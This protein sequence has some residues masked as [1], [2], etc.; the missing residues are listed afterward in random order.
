MSKSSSEGS[1]P[2]VGIISGALIL[3]NALALYEVLTPSEGLEPI[4]ILQGKMGAWKTALDTAFEEALKKN[5]DSVF[6]YAR[7][8]LASLPSAPYVEAALK[9]LYHSVQPVASK[10]TLLRND[11][12]GRVYHSALGKSIAKAYATFYTRI[13]TGELL[14]WFAIDDYR[15]RVSDF[16]C[17]SGTLLVASY[18]KKL[19]LAF[20]QGFTGSISDLHQEF[21]QDEV[22]GFDA[23]PFAS[24]L[25]L[26][27]LALQQPAVTFR[28]GR[29]YYVPCG[30][31]RMGSLDLLGS[32]T[33]A[34]QQRLDGLTAHGPVEQAMAGKSAPISLD[35]PRASFDLVIMNP[36]FTRNDRASKVLNRELLR[37]TLKAM[38]EGLSVAG[39]SAPFV[40]LAHISLKPGGRLAF[41]LPAAVLFADSWQPVRRLLLS[42]YHVE[43]IVMTWIPGASSFSE[44][45]DFREVLL[46]ARKEELKKEGDGSEEDEPDSRTL[47]AHLDRQFGVLEA[48]EIAQGL[49]D[50]G[51]AAPT[52]DLVKGNPGNITAS[53][54]PFGGVLACSD[55]L[56]RRSVDNW[57]RLVCIRD[58]VLLRL[59]LN[60]AGFLPLPK[61]P[62]GIQLTS[63]VSPISTFADVNLFMKNV[64]TAGYR[65]YE[66]RPDPGAIPFVDGVDLRR[67]SVRTSDLSWTKLDP[68]LPI[69]ERFTPKPAALQVVRKTNIYSSLRAAATLI[70]DGVGIGG[71]YF[72]VS[73]R[74]DLNS[75]D[76]VA[77]SSLDVSKLACLWFNSTPGLLSLLV[78][79]AETQGAY[80]SWPTEHMRIVRC[81]DPAKLT[82]RE[83]TELLAL[84][85]QVSTKEFEPLPTQVERAQTDS[86]HPRRELDEQIC[87]VLS[88]SGLSQIPAL[89]GLLALELRTLRDIM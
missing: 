24:H 64:E 17:G 35:V 48:R 56:L 33:V 55:G 21:I 18:H 74:E 39:L 23:M 3:F 84:W 71:M 44:S 62:L 28:A 29:I 53:G 40:Q 87:R 42:D 58:P 14:A 12:S 82:R 26:V 5:Y 25:T 75:K 31:K 27:N 38:G 57:Y 88:P 85:P 61:A 20:A 41:V 76:G 11:L 80:M 83:L 9:G 19:A 36:P 81:L 52:L 7:A 2:E 79:R 8:V 49:R 22:W 78:E 69:S 10:A 43:L 46:V 16:A 13:P 30:G 1:S 89:Y 73:P 47:L 65:I 68:R 60:I 45:S 70:E 37:K 63:R 6:T 66:A 86:T 15:A 51:A 67:M 77:I 32:P 72:P 54:E 50:F 59:A 4:P 34:V